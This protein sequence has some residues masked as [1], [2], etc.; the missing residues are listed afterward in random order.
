M[1]AWLRD[2]FEMNDSA[3]TTEST[4]QGSRQA[5]KPRIPKKITAAYL[6]RVAMNYMIRY[7]APEAQLRR[8][9]MRRCVLSCRHHDVPLESVLPHL[10]HTMS[11]MV[12]LQLVDDQRF[13]QG[14][15]ASLRRKGASSRMIL[16]KLAA[17][18]VS[19]EIAAAS[20][21]ADHVDDAEAAA[22]MAQRKRIGPWRSHERKQNR[23]RDLAVLARAGFSYAVAKAAIDADIGT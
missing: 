1:L 12:E 13:S 16:G 6:E 8:V 2:G 14:R 23:E 4:R 10:D 17:K 18:G 15:V 21:I 22:R 9:L 19:R 20:L 7:S 3:S 5:R 11:K